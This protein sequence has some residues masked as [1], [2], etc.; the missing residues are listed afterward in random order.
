MIE[1]DHEPIGALMVHTGTHPVKGEI[2]IVTNKETD[3]VLIH[4]DKCTVPG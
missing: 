2:V 1:V 3:A 4:G